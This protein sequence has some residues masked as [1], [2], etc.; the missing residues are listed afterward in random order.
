MPGGPPVAPSSRSWL[1]VAREILGAGSATLPTNTIP[2]DPKSFS[3]EDTPKFLPDEAIRGSMAMLFNEILGPEDATFS[4]GG[5]NFLDTHGFWLDNIFGDLSTIG[6]SPANPTSLS[7]SVATLAVG[8]TLATVASAT[9]YTNG[10]SVQI[11]SGNISEVVV[12]SAAPSGSLL[13]FGNNPLR[14]A[15]ASGATVSTVGSPYQHTFSLLNQTLG[16]GGVA[17]AQPPTHSITDNTNLNYSGTPGTNTSGARIYPGAAVSEISFTGNAEQLLDV[18]V[19][20][21]SWPSM[22]AGTTP[23]NT[24][25][26]VIPIANWR[27]QFYIGGTSAS[28]LVTD[29]GEW[30]VTVKREL[31]VYWTVQ[32]TP[33]PFIIARGPLSAT[34]ALNFTTEPDEQPLAYMLYSQGYNWL[35]FF[36]TN[37][38]SGGS[39]IT[40]NINSHA[41]QAVKAKPTRGDILIGFDDQFEAVAN[42]ADAGGSGGL[43]PIQVQITNQLPTY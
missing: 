4:F 27:G 10:A 28:N 17:G 30:A 15:H 37:S 36:M 22:P 40:L 34:W 16:Y 29:L 18:K 41:C 23:T 26:A 31:K 8:G 19:S 43:S 13:T 1:G 39:V 35:H 11:D 33:V 9:G 20:G 2:S 42:S 5:P 25:S 21:N 14:F 7:G 24:I 3:P 32:G 6:T 38:Y 12:L